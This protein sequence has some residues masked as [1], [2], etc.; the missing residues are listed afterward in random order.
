MK[1]ALGAGVIILIAVVIFNR[2]SS[3]SL[4]DYQAPTPSGTSTISTSSSLTAADLSFCDDTFAQ[5]AGTLCAVQPS[6]TNS[7][8]L[9]VSYSTGKRGDPILGFGYHAIGFPDD[10]ENIKGVWV[11][12]TGAYGRAYDPRLDVYSTSV[13][14]N[15]IMNEGYIVVQLGYDNRSSVNGDLCGKRNEGH[16]RDNCA[17]EVREA[18]L[19][20]LLETPFRSTD[21]QNSIDY[22]LASLF[23]YLQNN[24]VELPSTIDPENINW[25]ALHIS[26]HSQG[27]NQAYY[28]ATQRP[29][30]FACILAAGYDIAD[31]V[32]PG[33][34]NIADWFTAGNSATPL[35]NI[36]AMLTTSDDN[37]NTF[38][39]GLTQAVGLS[40]DE[41]IIADNT[42]YFDPEGKE[43]NGHAGAVG[44][45]SIAAKRAAA[46][47]K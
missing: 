8:I 3:S 43:I 2:N 23:T 16:D 41:I 14:L 39:A 31:S 7:N 42:Q 44:D 17:G 36:G 45:P 10:V 11:H 27:G 1:K 26:G 28:I 18:A 34:V 5:S 25:S 33:S 12:F 38:Y 35:S 21:E 46:C 47:F 20:G 32:S 19:T 29:V 4:D 6:K 9:D 40:A 22:R 37:Y 24:D 30:A 13:W 15:E